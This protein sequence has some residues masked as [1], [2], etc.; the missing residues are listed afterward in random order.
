VV[1]KKRATGA[2]AGPFTQVKAAA[3]VPLTGPPGS[4]N[5]MQ[6]SMQFGRQLQRTS[7]R[8]QLESQS[9]AV[10]TPATAM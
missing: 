1:K 10:C 6:Q 2:S 8:V 4:S 7:F 9:K 5:P 3:T